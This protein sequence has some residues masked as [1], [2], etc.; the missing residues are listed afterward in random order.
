MTAPIEELASVQHV[1]LFRYVTDP[2]KDFNVKV[3]QDDSS[4]EPKNVTFFEWAQRCASLPV[5]VSLSPAKQFG[6]HR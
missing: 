6:V 2:L 1:A 4:L 5:F 3:L